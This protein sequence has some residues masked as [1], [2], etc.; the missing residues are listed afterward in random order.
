MKKC[1]RLLCLCAVSL[2]SLNAYSQTSDA[3]AFHVYIWDDYSTISK[4]SDNGEWAVAQPA[5][6]D[7]RES[8][9]AKLVNLSTDEATELQTESDLTANGACGVSDVTDDGEIVVGSYKSAPAYWTKSTGEWTTLPVPSDCSGGSINAV[10]PDGKYAVGSAA[11]AVSIYNE[12]AVLWDLTT[13]SIVDLD[14]VPTLD[15]T[16][17]DQNQT[18]FVEISPDGRYILMSMS[19]SYVY[20]IAMCTYVID[21]E[22]QTV[23]AVGFTASDTED[24]TPDVENLLYV[25]DLVMSPSGKWLA[26]V[27]CLDDDGADSEI[28]MRYDVEN[29]QIE[30]FDDSGSSGMLV[31]AVDNDGNLYGATPT[32][33]PIREWSIYNGG[34]WYDFGDIMEQVFGVD[35]YEKTGLDNTGTPM[36]ISSDGLKIASMTNPSYGYCYV[37]D[38][39]QNL[40]ELCPTIDLLANYTVTPVSGASFAQLKTIEV[41]FERSISILDSDATVSLCY[42]NGDVIRNAASVAVDVSNSKN[43][44]ITFRTITLSADE[45]YVIDIPAGLVCISGDE[46]KTNSAIHIEYTGRDNVP[47]ATT[48]IYPAD[49][50]SMSK[51][52]YSS[53]YL[54]LYFDTHVMLSDNASATLTRVEDEQQIC[55][56]TLAVSNVSEDSDTLLLAYPTST[57]YLYNG[58]TYRVDIAEGSVTDLS[59]QGGNEAITLTY[60]GTY[61]RTISTDDEN[62]FTDDF[63]SPSSSLTNF[64][65]YE[66][67]HNEPAS[68]PAAWEFDAD[69]TPWSFSLRDDDGSDYCAGS[70]S[71]YSPAGQSDDWMVIPQIYIPDQYCHLSFKAQSYLM[72]KEDY[73][74]VIVWE[75]DEVINELTSTIVDQIREE[76][77]VVFNEKL[78]PGLSEDELADDWTDYVVDLA[79]YSEKNIYIAFL[80]DNEDQSAVFVDSVVVKHNLK[81]LLSLTNEESVVNQESINIAG[82]V[83][84]NSDNDTFTTIILTLLDGEGNQVD[85]IS[86]SGLALSKGVSFSFTFDDMPLTVGEENDFTIKLQLDDYN[87]IVTSSIKD[88][89]FKPTKRVIL[90]EFTGTTCVNCPLGIVA[91]ENLESIYGDQFIPI[92]IH[93]YT[94]DVLASGQS[95]YSSFLGL[96]GAPTGMINRNGVISSPVG[97]DEETFYYTF[98][99]GSNL[100]ADYV[101][102]EMEVPADIDINIGDITV[103]ED[104]GT[105]TVPLTVNSAL[106]ATDLNLNLFM[107]LLEDGIVSY[108]YNG[109]GSI[110]DPLLG[111]WGLG[112]AYSASVNYNI[113]HNDVARGSYG[114]TYNGTGGYLP[115]TMTAGEE[116][117]VVLQGAISDYL[118]DINKAKAVVMIIDANTDKCVNSAVGLFPGYAEGIDIADNSTSTIR[119]ESSNGVINAY[120]DGDI[121]VTAYTTAGT[122]LGKAAGNGNVSLSTGGY[123]GAVIVKAV[124]G[125]K[126][127]VK[128]LIAN[129]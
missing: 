100:W 20:P 18:R 121:N 96:T 58:Y 48:S 4:I 82:I 16:H 2:L 117:D 24:W 8:A 93:T 30:V 56:L 91:I 45:K 76:G 87:D 79:D 116:N 1:I 55:E 128:K 97:T 72:D 126:S 120:A 98:T 84:G 78:D 25:S 22:S 42:A 61:V 13:G 70:H 32:S 54:L 31:T 106:N 95:G 66:G 67:D 15:M 125:G 109:Y 3:P 27:V 64:M 53:N 44:I 85:Q 38:L 75:N 71:M 41:L 59:G 57:N 102:E 17:E 65:L 86:A 77:K 21:T 50:S 69:N 123:K 68:V 28:P 52:D 90:E 12:K 119:I 110:D 26:G 83:T 47:V 14:Y 89:A 5:Y 105:F 49:G 104:A 107:V 81:Y 114:L 11:Y 74:K 127:V 63:S 10:T 122:L 124:S 34:Y 19:F 23:D 29:Q 43:L 51:L 35:V 9:I 36:S 62:L 80:N 103:D 94:G 112:G 73:L 99:N 40:S 101:A 39:P 7:D 6:S 115:Q 33:N 108:Q 88:L 111:E 92:S 118:S 129:I 60:Y 37:A 113:T 46:D